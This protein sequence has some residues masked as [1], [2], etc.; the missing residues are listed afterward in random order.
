MEGEPLMQLYCKASDFDAATGVCAAPFYGP[1]QGLL[2][3]LT[4]A[5]GLSISAVL[6]TAWGV[7]FLIKRA[8]KTIPT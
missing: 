3:N 2:P 1:S 4:A 7:G 5:Q 8:R 6:I